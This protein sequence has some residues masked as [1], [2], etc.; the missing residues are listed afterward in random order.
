M[1]LTT[2][3]RDQAFTPVF[4]IFLS[5]A[6]TGAVRADKVTLVAE[7]IGGYGGPANLAKV[8]KPSAV[9]F[10]EAGKICS[11]Q[12]G[13]KT[14]GQLVRTGDTVGM[15]TTMDVRAPGHLG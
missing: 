4:A 6:S 7:D 11:G 2:H 9:A 10:D 15:I 3:S 12:F 8:S 1:Q 13:P 5:L 14:D